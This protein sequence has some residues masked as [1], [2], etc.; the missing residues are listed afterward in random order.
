MVPRKSM[1]E[2]GGRRVKGRPAEASGNQHRD[3]HP[4]AWRQPDERQHRHREER[5]ADEQDARV[6][7]VGNVPEAELRHRVRQLEAHLQ[8]ARPGQREIQVGDEQR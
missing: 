1:D 3:E 8:R 6:G 7:P 5:A 2:G 4:D